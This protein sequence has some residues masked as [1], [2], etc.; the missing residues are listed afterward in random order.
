MNPADTR[1]TPSRDEATPASRTGLTEA[2][3]VRLLAEH[4]PNAIPEERSSPVAAFARKFWGP[5][6]WMLEATL[7]LELT[8]GRHAQ[9]AIIGALLVLNAIVS[10]LQESRARSALELLR[11]RVS[12]GA[13]ALRS[14]AW[15]KIPAA[16]IV[17]GDLIHVR[18]GDLV[19]ADCRVVEGRILVDQS[20]LTGE[21]L[22]VDLGVEGATFSGSVVKRGEARCLV[23]ATGKKSL[24]GKTAELVRFAGARSHVEEVILGVV[25]WLLALDALLAAVV[26]GYALWIGHP[27]SDVVPFCLILLVASVPVALP[28]TFALATAFGSLELAARGVLV[29][30]LSA[31]EDAAGMDLLLSDKTGTITKNELTVTEVRPLGGHES[32]SVLRLAAV[33]SDDATQDPIDLAVVAA[34]RERRL[35]VP[36]ATHFVPFDP[37][38]RRSEATFEQGGASRRAVKG[39]PH[40]IA[41]L[42]G[43]RLDESLVAELAAKG[44]R[45]LAVA[46]GAG[47]A[48]EL[49]GLLGLED[50]PRSDSASTI[51][52]L[53]GLG[54]RVVMATGDAV[55]TARAIA[56]RVGI[57]ARV[58]APDVV[59]GKLDR[60]ALEHDVFAGVY[61]EDKFHLGEA[62]QLEGHIVGMTGDGVNDAPALKQAEVGIAVSNATDV[63]KAAASMVLTRPGLGEVVAA[64]EVGR[65]IFQRM[66]TYTLNKIVKTFQIA[67]FLGI[68]FLATGVFVTTPRHVLL[69]LFAND[70]VTMSLAT[71]RVSFSKTPDRWN[72]RALAGAGLVL[73]AF[74]LVFCFA[75]FFFGRD[76]LHLELPELQTLSFLVLVFTGQATVYL[77][78]ERGHFWRSRPSSYLLL[79]TLGDLIVVG[80][81][82]RYGILV[83]PVSLAIVLGTLGAS[84]AAMVLIDL[85]KAAI[86]ARV[87]REAR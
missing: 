9:G 8:L 41:E 14:R 43:D 68:G 70:F 55:E 26:F 79:A 82:A 58:A 19:P 63:A 47:E 77:A 17:P 4:G 57:G 45:V 86:F 11:E 64:V 67:L 2:E 25:R 36:P 65:G 23:T 37:A 59:R 50:P 72:L 30:R 29:T 53:R 83:A 62:F 35:A 78:R 6:P 42:A 44:C 21:S 27:I 38:T 73:A 84:F 80:L 54:V 24:Y 69:L 20:A 28:A 85:V 18:M 51:E 5:V 66:L 48:L 49:V 60:A 34:V 31:V 40:A 13:R 56:A 39:A 22:P 7:A 61:P 75:A 87:R 3:A 46:V 15:K 71:D 12:I 74:W 81:I 33:A 76:V 1:T 32:D 16:E 10:F 52:R